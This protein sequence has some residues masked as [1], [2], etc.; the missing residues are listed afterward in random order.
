MVSQEKFDAEAEQARKM[1][2]YN[3][4][5]A[6][7]LASEKKMGEDSRSE[8]VTTRDQLATA[9]EELAS[10]RD[11]LTTARDQ[12]ASTRGELNTTKDQLAARGENLK[13]LQQE[14]DRGDKVLAD[15]NKLVAGFQAKN[16]A[17][18]KELEK[19]RAD[20]K[21]AEKDKADL[22][23]KADA[24]KA[25]HAEALGAAEQEKAE[26]QKQAEAKRLEEAKAL[27]EGKKALETEVASRD[28]KIQDLQAKL[29]AAEAE[30]AALEEQK[31]KVEKEK[32]EKVDEMS[33][34]YDGLL[35]N[36]Q[37]ELASG[38]VTITK[39]KGQLS[40]KLLDAILFA[41][42]SADVKKE[43]KKVLDSVAK[44]LNEANDQTIVIEGHTDNVPL[45]GELAQ[46]FPSNWELSTARA[47]NVVRYLSEK[48]KIDP[49]RLT[50]AGYGEYRPVSDNTTPEGREKNRR[51]EIKLV[52]IPPKEEPKAE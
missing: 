24:L 19:T 46:K 5:L 22:Q 6:N 25:R 26:L 51:I 48:A 21:T 1:E 47:V 14:K 49:T 37:A 43:G 27:E 17:L 36:M 40:V 45:G 50:A 39:L 4:A 20:L 11:Q 2:A 33:K 28:A 44:A 35:K 9:R 13:N 31:A 42:G 18:N 38:N 30:R 41:S 29:T 10:T 12:L 52:P 16:D 3:V 15:T 23:A 7:R 8:L 34:T 32:V